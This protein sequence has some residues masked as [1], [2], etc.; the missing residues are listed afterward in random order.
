[1]QLGAG[2]QGTRKRLLLGGSITAAVAMAVALFS[3]GLPQ[4]G[5]CGGD[6][7]ALSAGDEAGASEQTDNERW[8]ASGDPKIFNSSLEYR[9]D[10]LPAQ[11]EASQPPW[12][13]S[14]WPTAQDNINYRWGGPS[15]LSPAAKYGKAF[16]V[17]GVEDAVS[18]EFG[19][20]SVTGAKSCTADS[21]C[22]SD[23]GEAC[24]K[25]TGQSAGRCIPTWWG[26]CHGW[27]PASILWPE[28]KHA[29]VK[30]GVTF[31]VMDLKALASLV[32]TQ[33][34]TKF[35]SLR[36]D[37]NDRADPRNFDK[38]GRPLKPEC[39]DSN[40]GTV[41]VLIANYLGK[42]KKGFAEDRTR[43]AEVWNQPLRAYRMLEKRVIT[44]Q[45]ANRLVGVLPEGGTTVSK[46]DTVAANAFVQVGSYDVVAGTAYKVAM[47]GSAGDADLYVRFGGAPSATAYDCRPYKKGSNEECAGTVP[48]G[49]TKLFVAV[50]GKATS[51]STYSLALTTGA[52]VPTAYV[53][54]PDAKGFAYVRTDLDYVSESSPDADGFLTPQLDY[55]TETDHYEYVLELDAAGKIIGGEWI[56]AS[57]M[58]HPDFLW[59]P[60]KSTVTA[61]AAGKISYAK[62][63]ALY[64]SSLK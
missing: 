59:L 24:A 7:A 53:F 34:Q 15:S 56:N 3:F 31:N 1:M 25:R 50:K 58:T 8:A 42:M 26:I 17:D 49:A 4:S 60:V 9:L 54:N 16:N 32:H 55:Y 18:K 37:A 48:A 41:H 22:S 12:T 28:P 2:S 62:V 21:Q 64:L 52:G 6:Q 5:G 23:D 20:E 38:Y 57:K 51:P 47:S 63:K 14:Y 10:A 11:G 44:A 46:T 45:E 61:V 39:R 33:T 19:I 29:V 27:T 36:C 35:V 30:N 43:D 40:A 13:G